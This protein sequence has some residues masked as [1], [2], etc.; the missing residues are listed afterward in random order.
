MY[1]K[2]IIFANCC[3][4]C[5]VVVEFVVES[6]SIT[7][8]FSGSRSEIESVPV[9]LLVTPVLVLHDPRDKRILSNFW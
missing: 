7:L 8:M 3:D 1:L 5:V 9:E 4:Y 2:Y 6:L